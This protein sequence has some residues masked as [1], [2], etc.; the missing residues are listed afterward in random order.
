[1]AVIGLI[2]G[3][4]V[5]GVIPIELA[6]NTLQVLLAGSTLAVGLLSD[7]DRRNRRGY[8]T[9]G[10]FERRATTPKG[11]WNPFEEEQRPRARPTKIQRLIREPD[12]LSAERLRLAPRGIFR[13]TRWAGTGDLDRGAGAPAH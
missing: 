9:D 3:H 5:L 2:D 10:R 12:R 13:V 1:M 11:C 8:S 7:R 6:D 4:D